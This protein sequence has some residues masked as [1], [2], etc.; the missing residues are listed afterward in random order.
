VVHCRVA[1]MSAPHRAPARCAVCNVV[2]PSTPRVGR[3]KFAASSPPRS[4]EIRTSGSRCCV[5]LLISIDRFVHVHAPLVE[6]RV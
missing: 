1:R 3:T 4:S 6:H 5:F 2:S